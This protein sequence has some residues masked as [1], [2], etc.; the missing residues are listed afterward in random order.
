MSIYIE[1]LG[2]NKHHIRMIMN[3]DPKFEKLPDWLLNNSMK[4]VAAMYMT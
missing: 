2:D 3:V 1:I 4:V